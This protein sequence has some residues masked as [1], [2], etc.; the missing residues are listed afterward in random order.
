MELDKKDKEILFELSKDSRQPYSK[1]AKTVKLKKETCIYK[2]HNLEKKGVIS[3]FLTLI[4]LSKLG[5]SHFKIYL[6]FHGASKEIIQNII[7]NFKDYYKINWVAK[8]IGTFDLIISV[9][10]KDI[11]EFN[12]EKNKILQKYNQYIKDYQIGIMADTYVYGK[13]YLVDKKINYLDD[14]KMIGDESIISLDESD[15]KILG[16]LVNDSRISFL[17]ISKKTNLN[18]KTV[19]SRVK[20]LEGNGVISGYDIFFNFNI[21]NLKY[22][23]LF[24]KINKMIPEEYKKFINYCKNNRNIVYLVENIG[25][26]ELE[27]EIEIN[28][29]EKFYDIVDEIKNN[30]PEFINQI[31]I[32]RIIHDYKH[33]YL[34]KEVLEKI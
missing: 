27:P 14:R 26:W 2:I 15:K 13:N 5:I 8:C 3:N 10:C 22:Y 25:S 18:I 23:K 16:L 19:I 9:L 6:R 31:D 11:K 29:E 33:I 17:D 24:I 4:S 30:F 7:K 28:S 32:V 34:P 20:K 21:I 12:L 1:I